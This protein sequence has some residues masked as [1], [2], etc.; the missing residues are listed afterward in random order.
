MQAAFSKGYVRLL[1]RTMRSAGTRIQTAKCLTCLCLSTQVSVMFSL[2]EV[3][4]LAGIVKDLNKPH[5]NYEEWSRVQDHVSLSHYTLPNLGN[6]MDAVKVAVR[7]PKE[8]AAKA[9]LASAHLANVAV[10]GSPRSESVSHR[11]FEFAF[12]CRVSADSTKTPVS[13]RLRF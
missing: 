7:C 1:A 6:V 13:A 12:A 9:R 8:K 5:D 2:K 3:M 10:G 11:A 4:S